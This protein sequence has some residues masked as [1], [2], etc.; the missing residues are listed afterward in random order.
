MADI[1]NFLAQ[2]LA[3][4]WANMAKMEKAADPAR[5]ATL[6]EC[7]DM[8]RMLANR[9]VTPAGTV[10]PGFY[11]F[12]L[13]GTIA[14]CGHRQHHID[15]TDEGWRRFFAACADDKPIKHVIDLLHR[16]QAAGAR[17][18]IWSGRSDET[19]EATR[20][21]L[22]QQAVN[23][24][25]LTKM[26]PA[27]ERCQDDHLKRRFLNESVYEGGVPDMVFDDRNQV[28]AMW[29]REGI[30]CAQVAPGDF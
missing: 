25:F 28:V 24:A 6:R 8:V 9:T 14:D 19:R 5:R 1:S 12:D 27:D 7:A 26:R 20:M 16:L 4:T 29:R 21:W 30:P 11:V 13:D 22:A 10:G 15:G 17:I 3:D 23:P 18:E 2:E